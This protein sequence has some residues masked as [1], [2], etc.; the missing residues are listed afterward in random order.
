M[1]TLCIFRLKSLLPL[2][3]IGQMLAYQPK[4]E[5]DED[6][7][8]VTDQEVEAFL[9]S[10]VLVT[11]MT[12]LLF[13]IFS[14]VRNNRNSNRVPNRYNINNSMN[15]SLSTRGQVSING[16]NEQ[17]FF[18]RQGEL[19]RRRRYNTDDNGS[20]NNS[21]PVPHPESK[22]KYLVDG[23]IPFRHGKA[24]NRNSNLDLWQGKNQEYLDCKE[25]VFSA[26]LG[27]L[28]A[29]K[30]CNVVLSIRQTDIVTS[31]ISE[32]KCDNLEKECLGESIANQMSP[33]C[34]VLAILASQYNLF[35]VIHADEDTALL[36]STPANDHGE[37]IKKI[38][39]LKCN[40]FSIPKDLL[41]RHRILCTSSMIGRIAIVRQLRPDLVVDFDPEI[42]KQLTRF[43]FSVHIYD[44]G[45]DG[46]HT[47][48]K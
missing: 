9:T 44:D 14:R 8:L 27:T 4:N 34:N 29:S 22:H 5:E 2:L 38:Q 37:K 7:E 11:F 32:S 47:L 41:P 10:V 17:P 26:V 1:T 43:G 15:N 18:S 42:Q 19:D 24:Y 46:L 16:Q 12:I 39:S 36:Q 6:M 30:G 20:E 25:R 45:G 33:L 48:V 40:L 31:D 23:I 3:N 21:M 28:A 35:V 13:S